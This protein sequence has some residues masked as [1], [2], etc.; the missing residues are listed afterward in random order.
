MG[1]R[2]HLHLRSKRR[3]VLLS[4][5]DGFTFKGIYRLSF[6]KQMVTNIMVQAL[7]NAYA[8]QGPKDKVILHT[9]LGSQYTSQDFKNLTSE[10]NIVQSFSLKACPYDNACIES[11][12]ATLKKEEVYQTTYISFEQARISLFQY[13]EGWY[14]RK[15]IHGSINYL[16]PEECEQL[17]R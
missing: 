16:T 9:D 8:S 13:I 7:K 3:L 6:S 1:I 14:N 17:E 4:F 5:S 11:F 2:Y 12:H 10:L 15:R